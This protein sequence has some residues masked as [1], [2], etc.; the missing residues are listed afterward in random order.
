MLYG[1]LNNRVAETIVDAGVGKWSGSEE[2]LSSV[3]HSGPSDYN[4]FQ[5]GT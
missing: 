1:F 2:L 5:W 4:L 3:E